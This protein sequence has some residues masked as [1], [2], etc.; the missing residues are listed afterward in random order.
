MS[1][2][3]TAILVNNPMVLV[4]SILVVLSIVE[5]FVSLYL[6]KMIINKNQKIETLNNILDEIIS[7]V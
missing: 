3:F 5:V 7:K 1:L 6:Y 2:S 4:I